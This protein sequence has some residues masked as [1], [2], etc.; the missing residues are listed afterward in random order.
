MRVHT[1]CTRFKVAA[2]W[3]G[4]AAATLI[5]SSVSAATPSPPFIDATADW[6]T[7]VNY[8]RAMAGVGPVF[9]DP[10]MSA[11]AALHS[12]Y[13]LFNG[14][15][16]DEIPGL[17]GYTAEGDVAGNSGNVAV[18]TVIDTGV[19]S[20][21]ELWMSGPFHAI[22]V[23]R[24]NLQSTGFGKCDLPATPAWHSGATFDV[25]RGLVSLPRPAAPI[26]FPGNGTT[27]NLDRFIVET[28]NP[29]SFCPGWSA[30]A[31]LPIIAMMPEAATSPTATVTGPNGP[32]EVC[33]LS[34]ANTIGVAQQILQ[35]DN[36]VVVV[37]RTVLAQ[38]MYNVT[39]GTTARVVPWTFT[40]D[41]A[42]LVGVASLPVAQ[43]AGPATGFAP[44]PPARIVDTRI[45]LGTTSR[46][47]GQVARRIQITGTGVV[48]PAAKAVFANVTVTNP[49]GSGFLTMWNCS[50]ARPDVSTLNFSPNETVANAATIPLDSTGGVC[51]FSNVSTDLVID[52]SGH[53][54]ASATG[55]YMPVAPNRLMDSREG[56]GTPARLVGQRAV[57][58]SVVSGVSGVPPGASA[59]ALNVTGV[60]PSADGF[61]TAYP[62]GALP[63]T[64]SLNPATGRATPNLVMAPVSP[65]GT[66]CFFSN[67]AVDLVVDVVG[68]VSTAPAA[69][70]TLTPTT[71][72]RFTDTRDL[73]RVE[74]NAGQGGV[75]LTASQ[76]L[77]VQMAGLRGIPANARAISANLTVVDAIAAGFLT[78]YPCGGGVPTASNV[79][80]V[81]G[82]AIANAAELPLSPSGAICIYS[83]SS[84]HVIID[85]NGW[86]S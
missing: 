77:P 69:T 72:F 30:P 66:V 62:C 54:S 44:L 73:L 29:L 76:T 32:I 86:W 57:E 25:I 64:S 37:P 36:A 81:V 34:A 68:Y 5:P 2:A 55:R 33:V 48:P 65:S 75:R 23:L 19:R 47:A 39:V 79:N 49:A 52:V 41:P 14:I 10:A 24:S 50:T 63:D 20:H 78:A 46:L 12:C 21:I 9:E 28:P 40:V 22:G 38:G 82:A 80:Y 31:G 4:L 45:T 74:V 35:G 17:T 3:L 71:P 53:Y 58:L 26:L 83:S 70:T 42:A 16:H 18:S 61:V 8:Y 6:L 85:V 13:M 84:A 51:A 56:L 15:T 1:R 43:P 27:T 59:V 11:G 7:T 60:F 67:V